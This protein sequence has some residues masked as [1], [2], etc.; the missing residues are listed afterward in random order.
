MEGVSTGDARQPEGTAAQLEL[1][2]ELTRQN[3]LISELTAERDRLQSESS[4]LATNSLQITRL[5]KELKDLTALLNSEV[6]SRD[7]QIS[8][9]KMQL[10]TK[11]RLYEE[12]QKQFEEL[13]KKATSDSQSGK[14]QAAELSECQK[15]LAEALEKLRQ[16]ELSGSQLK[17]LLDKRELQN[18]ELKDDLEALKEQFADA[19]KLQKEDA[20]G[21]QLKCLD[22]QDEC[23]AAKQELRRLKKLVDNSYSAE[24]L[25]SSFNST[26]NSFNAQMNSTDSSI[27]YIINSMDVDLKAQ[28]VKN[29]KQQVRFITDLNSSSENAMSTIKI[30][31]RAIP[32]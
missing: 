27:S 6:L 28:I 17:N 19:Q 26:I 9:L 13:Q 21:L 1:E 18:T 3:K 12:L 32:K 7:D 4:D 31:I 10:N 14:S 11:E 25:A 15:H 2:L 23:E 16:A 5:N 20:D 30:S 29:E 8:S 22:L 24:E